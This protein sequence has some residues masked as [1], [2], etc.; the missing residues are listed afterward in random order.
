MGVD[1]V[2]KNDNVV[3]VEL[4]QGSRGGGGGH[5]FG[6]NLGFSFG[7]GFNSLPA[8]LGTV[9]GQIR[10]GL[11]ERLTHLQAGGRCGGNQL[12]QFFQDTNVDG[13][14]IHQTGLIRALLFSLC[15]RQS[16]HDHRLNGWLHQR[17]GISGYL[18]G[19]DFGTA[20]LGRLSHT[21]AVVT[22]STRDRF[23]SLA[24]MVLRSVRLFAINGLEG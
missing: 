23:P 6:F 3:Y 11:R 16:R 2:V 15:L 13:A 14:S 20:F 21:G 1:F 8:I 10:T 18:L 17:L 9:H 7:C 12:L 19:F 24:A 22:T 4:T 5:G